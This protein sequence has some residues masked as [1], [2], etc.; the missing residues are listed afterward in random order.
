MR[1]ICFASIFLFCA[2]SV[3][4]QSNP[5]LFRCKDQKHIVD[6]SINNSGEVVEGPTCAQIIVNA[7][8]YGAN[9]GKT[10]SYTGGANLPSIFPSTFSPGGAQPA[11]TESLNDHFT[12]DFANIQSLQRQLSALEATDRTTG[13][14]A[15][16]YLMTL[17]ALIS[18]SDETL[19]LGGPKAVV[20]LVKKPATLKQINDLING[21]F[22]WKTT[23][24]IIA[25]LQTLQADLNAL[26]VRFSAN[27]GT[28]T[29]DPCSDTNVE[30]LGWTDWI[31]CRGDQYKAA[32]ATAA[33][34]LTEAGSW[35]SDSDK[36]MQF[37]KKIGIVQYWLNTITPL[38]ED[39]FK[40]QAEVRC[41]VLFNKNEQTILKLLLVDRISVF[42]GQIAQP[43]VKDGLLT[44]TCASP[45]ALTAGAAFSTI[46]NQ[47]FAVVKSVP[48]SGTTS[49]NTFGVT[50]DSRI[51]PYPIAMAH[52]RL[53]DWMDDRYALH[54][55]F[56]VGANVKGDNSGGSSPEFL[57]GLSISFWRTIFVTGGLDVGKQSK[58]SG[59][60]NLGDT[61]PTDITNPPVSS[62]YKAGFGFAITFTQP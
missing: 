5:A 12:A 2:V 29:G 8:R 50:S 18:E 3:H 51:N 61:V 31:K 39:S 21:A 52:A 40:L 53:R 38:S 42:D 27:T 15:D 7:V 10:V 56:G 43:Q 14:D 20:D 11:K 19:K 46:Q 55:S 41:G 26:P 22:N 9:L 59:G 47:Q 49:I 58:L 16:K 45:F 57:T 30:Q 4:A 32:Q 60:F 23:D 48:P 13:S 1:K 28:F 33:A 62:S 54:Y 36:A 44:V 35:T 17:R 6:L 24:G 25:E 34:T 37:A